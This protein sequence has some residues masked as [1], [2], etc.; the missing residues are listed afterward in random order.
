MLYFF[1]IKIILGW[2]KKVSYL[3]S[4]SFSVHRRRRDSRS[5]LNGVESELLL[6]NIFFCEINEDKWLHLSNEGVER[7]RT[8]YEEENQDL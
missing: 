3:I 7:D 1:V 6:E 5:S 8:C 4:V 2:F